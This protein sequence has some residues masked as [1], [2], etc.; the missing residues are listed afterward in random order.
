M[1]RVR[2][3]T[4]ICF[5]QL[6]ES[7]GTGL[8]VIVIRRLNTFMPKIFPEASGFNIIRKEP[9]KSMNQDEGFYQQYQHDYTV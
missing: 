2:I 7:P 5:T 6:S 1:C 3:Y 4:V 9:D 8:V